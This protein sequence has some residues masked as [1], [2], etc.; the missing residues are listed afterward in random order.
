[1]REDN[2]ICDGCGAAY[3]HLPPQ[4]ANCDGQV[5][6]DNRRDIVNAPSHY[7][8][9]PGIE[10]IDVTKHFNFSRG[11]A[12]KYIWR[13]GKKD[14]SKEIED[15][16]KAIKYLEIEIARVENVHKKITD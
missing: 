2:Y 11:S 13:A 5:F 12:I 7:R 6:T 8:D 16:R 9:I 15:L 1:M 14:K 3:T 10:C 4:C